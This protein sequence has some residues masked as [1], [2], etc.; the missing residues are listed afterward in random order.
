[1]AQKKTSTARVRS[2]RQQ[3]EE[4]GAC[5][6]C[7]KAP[8][9]LHLKRC[10]DCCFRDLAGR[11]LKDPNQGPELKKLLERQ[12]YRCA[13]SGRPI[14]IGNNASVEHVEPSSKAKDRANDITNLRFVDMRINQM[15]HSMPLPE[16]IECC[17]SVLTHFGYEVVKDD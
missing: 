13:Y 15:K 14:D 6:W 5:T 12:R 16:L 7:G 10:I 8:R 1:M 2:Y 3:L 11:H 4:M 9:H 17:K